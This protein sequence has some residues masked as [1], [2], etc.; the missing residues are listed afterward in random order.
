MKVSVSKSVCLG[1]VIASAATIAATAQTSQGNNFVVDTQSY[2]GSDSVRLTAAPEGYVMVWNDEFDSPA[3]LTEKWI[4]MT[5][6]P[7]R[8]NHE[9]QTYRPGDQA[10]EDAEGNLRH[11][12]EVVDGVL[13]INCFKGA[14]GRIYSAR[15][16][17]RQEGSPYN[18]VAGW[19]HGYIEA[20]IRIPSGLGTW[21]A[22][23]MMPA[24]PEQR[25][26]GWP[27]CGEIDILEE[28]GADPDEVVCSLHAKGHNHRDKT[29]VS[30]RR[31]LGNMENN[32]LVYSMLWDDDHIEIFADGRQILNYPNDHTGNDNWPYDCAYHATLNL[33]WGGD[34][35]GYKGVDESALPVVMEVDY[36][37]VYQKPEAAAK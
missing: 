15:M 2:E 26:L 29:Q 30:A 31:Q 20:R 28:V 25:K 11:T 17:S 8:V 9:L 32:W 24:D 7:Q 5:W 10:I 13:R 21:P 35:G 4:P 18:D 36:V 19:K 23:W 12:A 14:D 16:D 3:S 33:A 34:W 1:L 22:F 6:E 37:R 27:A